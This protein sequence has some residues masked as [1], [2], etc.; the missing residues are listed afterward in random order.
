MDSIHPRILDCNCGCVNMAKVVDFGE[1]RDVGCK[2]ELEDREFSPGDLQLVK[3]LSKWEFWGLLLGNSKDNLKE[4]FGDSLRPLKASRVIDKGHGSASL[5]FLLPAKTPL[6]GINEHGKIRVKLDDRGE[7]VFLS[8]TDLRFYAKDLETPLPKTVQSVSRRLKSG[9]RAIL[10]VGL[11]RAW[12]KPGKPE[13]HWLQVNNIH[14][15]DDPTWQVAYDS[16]W[17]LIPH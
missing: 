12:G 6:I 10:G 17:Q 2:P 16:G 13:Y 1:M 9:V 3:S 5:G 4:I 8:L 14:M 7:S 15:E 11:T